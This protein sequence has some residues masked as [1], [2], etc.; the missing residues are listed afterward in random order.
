M[1]RY[2]HNYKCSYTTK[3]Y[4]L[5]RIILSLILGSLFLSHVVFNG[6]EVFYLLAVGLG[7]IG[8][9][10][11]K[12]KAPLT[13]YPID[14]VV[15]VLFVYTVIHT[16]FIEPGSFSY[17]RFYVYISYPLVYFLSRS[18]P[19]GKDS[20]GFVS[21]FVHV[22]MGIALLEGLHA[23]LQATGRLSK[24]PFANATFTGVFSY[25]NFLGLLLAMGLLGSVW[26]WLSCI[27][28]RRRRKYGY[29]IIAILLGA[30]VLISQSRGAWLGT[31]AALTVLFSNT[32]VATNRKIPVAVRRIFLVGG[33]LLLLLTGYF[34]YQLKPESVKGRLFLSAKTL[35]MIRE[36]P[37][38][39]YGLLSFSGTYNREKATY[40]VQEE[41]PFAE[42]RN[43]GYVFTPFNE[44]LH[45]QFGLGLLIPVAFLSIGYCLLRH[46]NR[47]DPAVPVLGALIVLTA[48]YSL[49]SYPLSTPHLTTIAVIAAALL[50]NRSTTVSGTS[51]TS[52]PLRIV[53]MIMGGLL[54]YLSLGS[55]RAKWILR[56]AGPG[57]S[58]A[59]FSVEERTRLHFAQ[60]EFGLSEFLAG[61]TLFE[62]G[63]YARGLVHLKHGFDQMPVPQFG[64]YLARAYQKNGQLKKAEDILRFNIGNQPYRFTPRIQYARFLNQQKRYAESRAVYRAILELPIKVPS[65]EVDA[66][67]KEAAQGIRVP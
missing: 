21:F 22:V 7:L 60:R 24:T 59:T 28:A 31:L 12:P 51:I 26:Q 27:K 63:S 1:E 30:M 55:L 54:L 16:Y 50:V 6:M 43:G 4:F 58:A 37:I 5:P 65:A 13:V 67:K 62:S 66:Y 61:R 35:K 42:M 9:L 33:S 23:V 49:T 56:Q 34:A 15:F 3:S 20:I 14:G 25:P 11:V 46:Y 2:Y 8:S 10:L 19:A 36:K 38:F 40:F 17:L 32:I 29:L 47:S 64:Q 45:L 52:W 39:G 57:P 18:L 41:R 53:G 44:L 48:A